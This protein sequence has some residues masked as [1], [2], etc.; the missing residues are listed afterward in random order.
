MSYI[1]EIF[2]IYLHTNIVLQMVILKQVSNTDAHGFF[3]LQR[4]QNNRS[5]NLVKIALFI[6]HLQVTFTKFY[7]S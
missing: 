1:C 3:L 7:H 4:D 6:F 5:L 2:L